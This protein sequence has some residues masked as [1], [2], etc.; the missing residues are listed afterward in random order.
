M[1]YW[2]GWYDHW[3][4]EH[5]TFPMEKF[6]ENLRQILETNASVN[7]YMYHGGTNF[8]FMNGVDSYEVDP[9]YRPTVTS[10][11]YDALLSE[12]GTP[13]AK[14]YHAIK[15]MEELIPGFQ[16]SVSTTHLEQE[17]KGKEKA[18]L[19]SNKCGDEERDKM[20]AGYGIVNLTKFMSFDALLQYV[21]SEKHKDAIPMELLDCNEGSGQ[22]YGFILYSTN[23]TS[24]GG[25]VMIQGHVRDRAQIWLDNMKITTVDWQT[26]NFS[27]SIPASLKNHRL[28][29]FVENLGRVNYQYGYDVPSFVKLDRQRK[30]LVENVLLNGEKLSNWEIFPLQWD[31]SFLELLNLPKHSVP[32][33]A[34]NCNPKSVMQPIS[35]ILDKPALY[36]GILYLPTTPEDTF[37]TLDGWD[38][39]IVFINN[40]NVGRYWKIGPQKALYVPAPL[41]RK[42]RNTVAVFELHE[43]NS[44]VMFI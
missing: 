26:V 14:Y 34:D 12:N 43:A 42:G 8:G 1:E 4:E 33:T 3:G 21:I 22:G 25:T 9:V 7:F 32:N 20:K 17:L 5:S 28:D 23:F 24:A 39:G 31:S 41:L 29:I 37:I 27:F 40:F 6:S 10:Y 2:C 35:S 44:H 15:L 18:N 19:E 11:D 38:K 13:T 16:H 30:G 36:T